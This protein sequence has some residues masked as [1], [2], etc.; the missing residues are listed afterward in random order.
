MISV[1]SLSRP[2]TEFGM[3]RFSFVRSLS[4]VGSLGTTT[5]AVRV[6]IPFTPL[7][8][9]EHRKVPVSAFG[10][11]RDDTVFYNSSPSVASSAATTPAV[12]V[13]IPFTPLLVSQYRKVPLSAFGRVRDDT[14]FYNSNS[15]VASFGTTA[16]GWRDNTVFAAAGE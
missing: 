5:P 16:C 15:Y 9:N 13:L 6:V 4:P 8:V 12:R 7:L 1:R 10:R 11:V 14:V 2:L 3:P